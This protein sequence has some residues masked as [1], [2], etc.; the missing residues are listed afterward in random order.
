[1]TRLV[2]TVQNVL[3]TFS[4]IFPAGMQMFKLWSVS[5][6]DGKGKELY[7]ENYADIWGINRL[8]F[9]GATGHGECDH[10]SCFRLLFS[11]FMEACA[12]YHSSNDQQF[13]FHD[14]K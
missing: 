8:H 12:E 7:G 11:F 1:M 14:S 2:S 9:M 3:H 4:L 5:V 13:I 10:V 6:K